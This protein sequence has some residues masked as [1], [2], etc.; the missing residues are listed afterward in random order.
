MI[1]KKSGKFTSVASSPFQDLNFSA[2]EM[3]GRY[4]G[5][6]FGKFSTYKFGPTNF[7]SVIYLVFFDKLIGNIG[8]FP[9]RSS[10]EIF[11]VKK[12]SQNPPK[13]DKP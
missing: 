1:N 2:S 5:G 9:P 8:L 11:L 12:N 13:E 4:K 3:P 7:G 6:G 10:E